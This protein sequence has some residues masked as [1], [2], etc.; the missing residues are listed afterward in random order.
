MAEATP[1]DHEQI[2]QRYVE[3]YNQKDIDVLDETVT[4][5]IVVHG[6]I[7]ADGPVRG[8]DAYK[9]W[10]GQM[11]NGL[12]DAKIEIQDTFTVDD[13][14]AARW[15]VRGTH[16]GDLFGIPPTGE[17]TEVTGLALFRIEDGKIAEKWYQQDDLRLLQQIGAVPEQPTP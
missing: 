13:R 2:V 16:D 17:A 7:G 12:P 8:I 14:V 9:E 10:A 15:T 3:G 5:D 11:L 6:L 4:D 1:E